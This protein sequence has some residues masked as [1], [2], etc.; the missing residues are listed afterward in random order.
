MT[1]QQFI[2]KWG[3]G[4]SAYELNERQGAQ[5]HF[6]E[7]CQLLGVPSPGSSGDYLFEQETALK[8]LLT[9]SLALSK[10][11]LRVVNLARHGFYTASGQKLSS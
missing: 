2:A 1:A 6:I 3:P 11:P 4:G 10:L 5:Q 9:N 7:L 8:P